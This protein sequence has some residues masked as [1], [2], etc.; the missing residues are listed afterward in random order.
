M[1]NELKLTDRTAGEYYEVCWTDCGEF[2]FLSFKNCPTA[3]RN[4]LEYAVANNDLKL[5]CEL[6]DAF[7]VDVE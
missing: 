1:E 4:V 3:L 7:I 5:V 2:S 6:W